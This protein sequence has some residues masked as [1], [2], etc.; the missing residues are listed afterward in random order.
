MK[1]YTYKAFGIN[2]N[3][4]NLAGVCLEEM[5]SN[6]EKQKIAKKLGYS[7]TAF[8][9]RRSENEF[10]IEFFTPNSQIEVCG[11]ATIASFSF[12]FKEKIITQGNYIMDTTIGTFSVQVTSKGKVMMEQ[13]LPIF[14]GKLDKEEIAISLGIGEDD[15]IDNVPINIVST[16]LKD[17]FIGVKNR[18]ILYNMKPNFQFI[19]EI[20]EKYKC[21]GY[22]VYTLECDNV[23]AECRNF[24]PLYDIDEECATGTSSGALSCLL[25][26]YNMINK[27]E[28]GNIILNQGKSMDNPCEIFVNLELYEG[29]IKSVY[30]GGQ[31]FKN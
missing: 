5:L 11:H 19:K 4:G 9:E 30:V 28:C 25:Y 27:E 14:Y 15:I 31:A 23:A 2:K 12:L 29:E 16:G 10:K 26:K 1:L 22:H 3:Y 6:K 13:K 8:I 20:S 17:I 24:A 21:I 7:E 18:E